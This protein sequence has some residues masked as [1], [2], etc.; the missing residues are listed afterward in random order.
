[1]PGTFLGVFP[2]LSA[3]GGIQQV[4][5]HVGATLQDLAGREDRPCRLIGL[6]D[7]SGEGAFEV[8]GRE[9]RFRG[10]ARNK[11]GFLAHLACQAPETSLVFAG[12]VNLGPAALSM[13]ALQRRLRFWVMVHGTEVW[14]PLPLARRTALR[15]ANGILAVSR[16]TANA[17]ERVQGAGRGK[18]AVLHPA[19]DPAYLSSDADAPPAPLPVPPGSRLLLT[20][21]RLLA[22]EP[23]K[24]VDTVI[25]AM[26]RL[27]NSFPTLHYVVVGDGDARPSLEKLAADCGVGDRVIFT[28]VRATES[29][30]SCYE[31]ADVF[32]MPSRQE[33]F[34][35]V[36]LEAMAAGKPVVGGACGGAPEVVSDGETGFLVNYGDVAALEQRLET[37]LA[38]DALRRRMG[39]AGRR[40]AETQHHFQ[41]FRERLMAILETGS[42]GVR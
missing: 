29:L 14:E 21:G 12:H 38:D 31:A 28:R 6:N 42:E 18:I 33:G 26:P 19:L 35:I 11:A 3:V 39:D 40:K 24:G 34:G 9:Y 30:R 1:M 8:A 4:S 37:L 10:F 32:V 5:R 41:Q 13:R 2:E 27:A 20:V 22:S 15:K 17:V 7:P 23:G 36:F 25:R 16:Y